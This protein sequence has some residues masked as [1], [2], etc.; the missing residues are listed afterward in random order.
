[1]VRTPTL[2]IRSSHEIHRYYT[3]SPDPVYTN[4]EFV[5]MLWG[6]KSIN[7]FTQTINQTIAQENVNAIL[8]MNECVQISMWASL[9]I[10]TATDQ[11]KRR[12]R[13]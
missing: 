1:M 10:Y 13:I 8:G 4:L 9:D 11:T 5:P 3:W 6:E 12:S 7:D 2:A